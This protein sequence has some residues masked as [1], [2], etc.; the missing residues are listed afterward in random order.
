V[1]HDR[2]AL[3]PA[4][5]AET[6]E[7]AGL[8]IK[9]GSINEASRLLRT[10]D[11]TKNSQ[12]RLFMAFCDIAEWDY[13]SATHH[14]KKLLEMPIEPYAALVA[15]VNLASALI[16][17]RQYG[18][19]EQIIEIAM[20]EARTNRYM[21]LLANL[22]ELRTQLALAKN[23]F[24]SANA[25]LAAA[26]LLIGRQETNDQMFLLK[27]RAV[28]EAKT[29][30]KVDPLLRFRNQA[31][32][33]AEWES[34]RECDYQILQLEFTNSRFEHLMFG[35]PH[36]HFRERVVSGLGLKPLDLN[37]YVLGQHHGYPID[38]THGRGKLHETLVS[39]LCDFYAPQSIGMLFSRLFPGEYYHYMHSPNRVHQLLWRTR[40]WL[41]RD[42]VPLEIKESAGLFSVQLG[43]GVGVR[44]PFD[45][46]AQLRENDQVDFP[47]S[48]FSAKDLQTQLTLSQTTVARLIRRGLQ[49]GEIVSFRESRSIR[50]KK[51]G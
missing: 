31:I 20:L 42:L 35:T 16:N 23:D 36:R 38:L 41:K 46:T 27:W 17:T 9:I 45:R 4:T 44:I 28:I 19:A 34:L 48:E 30:G 14:L 32:A 6:A 13:H 3:A 15:Q 22:L 24:A 47:K 51:A 12:I 50:Y 33:R 1:H 25:D 49:S 5:D 18:E 40:E 21:R 39:L 43:I 29:T 10:L 7:Y 2:K 11:A 8:L 37:I 26:E